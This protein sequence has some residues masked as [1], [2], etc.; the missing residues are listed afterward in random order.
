MRLLSR[1]PRLFALLAALAASAFAVSLSFGS[2][3]REAP[4]HR[5]RP[6]GGQH[7][8]VRVHGERRHRID[9][10][11]VANWIP[12][13]DPGRRPELLQLRRQGADYYIN[14]DN[15]GDGK[16]DVRYRFKFKTHDREHGTRSCTRCPGVTSIN[17]PKL[18]VVQT[19]LDV[20][21]EHYRNGQQGRAR[22]V[23]RRTF[24]SRRTTSGP[25]TIPNYS[26]VA[27]SGD[28][29]AARRRQ[30]VRRPASTIRSSSTSARRSTRSTSAT[31]PA[32][33]A[34]AR[35][36][37]R[38][39]TSTRSCCRSRSRTSRATARPSPAPR[40][41]NAVVGV[42]STH[43]AP[44]AA[45]DR[46]TSRNGTAHS[47]SGKRLRCRSAGSATRWSTRSSSRSG[48]RTSSTA[49]SRTDDAA[50][51]RQVRRE[52]ASSARLINALFGLGVPETDRTDIVTALL[53]GHPGPDADRAERGRRPTR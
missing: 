8:P 46:L 10:T 6:D 22:Q 27:D 1:A 13:E 14:I 47:R 7:R 34:A 28:Q 45:G 42:W 48:R 29:A 5:A 21:R 2:S 35:T 33:R 15:T 9:L 20:T 49:T 17:D 37:S 19:L 39:T 11:V 26:A 4:L 36:T 31:A 43:G 44:A 12:F 25:K 52:A 24:R 51:L 16:P 38:A 23:S 50:N 53:T 18:N 3:H 40:P 41:S 30:G 32:T